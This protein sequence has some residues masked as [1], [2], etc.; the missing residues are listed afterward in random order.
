MEIHVEI[1]GRRAVI[2][3]VATRALKALRAPTIPLRPR[4][5]RLAALTARAATRSLAAIDGPKR[6]C[7]TMVGGGVNVGSS[8][9]AV[10]RSP[11]RIA[12]CGA[13][14]DRRSQIPVRSHFSNPF[15]VVCSCDV[16]SAKL[17]TESDCASVSG[18]AQIR[19]CTTRPIITLPRRY[20]CQKSMRREMRSARPSP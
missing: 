14:S 6:K 12:R 2:V 15:L 1:F 20:A 5:A 3:R 8:S 9:L 11:F 19:P 17:T 18:Q 16:T 4:C 7:L 13:R 10:V